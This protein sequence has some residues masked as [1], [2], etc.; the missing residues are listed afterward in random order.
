MT[1]YI[2]RRLALIFPTLFGIILVNFL[3]IQFVPGG[4]I[5]QIL[6]QLQGNEDVFE[7]ISGGGFETNNI[8]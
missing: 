6:S 7:N 4:P 5:E 8:Q 2:F 3:L 1:S